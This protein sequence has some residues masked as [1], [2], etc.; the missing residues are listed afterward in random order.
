MVLAVHLE[1]DAE[2]R[3]ARAEVGL[4]LE[5]DVAAGDGK[6]PFAPVSSSK[7]TVPSFASTFLMGT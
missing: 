4:P 7:V 3:P 6:R 2:R 1:I 5:L